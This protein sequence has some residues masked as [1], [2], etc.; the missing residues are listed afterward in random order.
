MRRL[1]QNPQRLLIAVTI[2][3]L[4]VT[5][6][7][8]VLGHPFVNLD[9]GDYVTTNPV[10][11]G[12][13]SKSGFAWAFSTM[14]STNW[15][16]LTWLSHMVDVELFGLN[17]RGHHLTSLLLH[18]LNSSLLFLLLSRMTGAN[19]PSAFA[20][21]AFAVHPLRVE[22]VAW[23]AERKDVLGGLFW[24]LT[25]G[26]YV[27]YTERATLGRYLCVVLLFA[28]GLMAKPMLVTL[29]FALLLLDYWPLSRLPRRGILFGSPLEGNVQAGGP[30]VLVEK[31]PL[32][33]LTVVSCVFTYTA[34]RYGGALVDHGKIP[35]LV[36]A[37][38]AL[39]SY[40]SYIG[41]TMWPSSLAI[42]YPYPNAVPPT[43]TIVGA[44]AL[45]AGAIMVSIWYGKRFPY[46]PVGLFWFA[47]TLI[48]VIGLVQVGSQGMADRY[49]YIPSI[50]LFIAFAWGIRDLSAG[51]R[52][53]KVVLACLFGVVIVAMSAVTLRQ[54]TYWSS[55]TTLFTHA[56]EVTSGNFLAESNLGV[57]LGRQGK[58]E[59]AIA[60]YRKAIAILPNFVDAHY[61]LAV[62]LARLG[63]TDEAI[64]S[65]RKTL[66]YNPGHAFAHNNL[67]VLL[68]ERG[69]LD[70]AIAQYK[71]AIRI[72][73]DFLRAYNNL[74][75]ALGRQGK[76]D[77][78][79]YYLS[80]A[81]RL[82][83]QDV[84]THLNLGV[85]WQIKGNLDEA[86][87]HFHEAQSLRPGDPTIAK[88]L[89]AISLPAN[90]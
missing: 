83:P 68:A 63:R 51:W 33:L 53:R 61:N 2:A 1:A 27:R 71:E 22:S 38:N 80:Q 7:W 82:N 70:A 9:D 10:V 11:L 77:E 57:A 87:Y 28:L 39:V 65:Y 62:D 35:F 18:A 60:H 24:I 12:G 41:K 64:A 44:A 31:I 75:A 46:L 74:G 6:F 86:L 16:P 40:A 73:H 42:F 52:Q 47:G 69:E 5:V 58:S 90:R 34:S 3:L 25:M 23:I 54:L 30:G 8:Q 89:E 21:A 14:H 48:P 55:S 49:T 37:T 79:I 59:E 56:I 76:L 85:A 17:P 66:E 15:H 78:S 32:F 13:L 43:W 4:A 45:A 36:K 88:Q 19:W 67:G 50:G 81:A 20:A 26:A 84:M 29:P 72:R